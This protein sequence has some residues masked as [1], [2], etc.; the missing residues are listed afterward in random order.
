[1]N[2]LAFGS[3]LPP[4]IW[5]GQEWRTLVRNRLEGWQQSF[6]PLPQGERV[7]VRVIAFL[8]GLFLMI[9]P[10]LCKLARRGEGRLGGVEV[11]MPATRALASFVAL[12]LLTVTGLPTTT[13]CGGSGSANPSLSTGPQPGVIYYID[14]HLGSSH[15]ITDSLGNV[16]REESRFPYGLE[17]DTTSEATTADYVYTGKEYDAETGLIY[18]GGRYYAP[19]LGRWITPDPL[20]LNE[21]TKAVENPI[22]SNLYT[23][24][25][26]NP[27]NLID[28]NGFFEGKGKGRLDFRKAVPSNATERAY[29]QKLLE[30][31]PQAATALVP[32]VNDFRD[33]YELAS[34]RDL[35]TGNDI[36]LTGRMFSAFGLII[37]SGAAY[38]GAKQLAKFNIALGHTG[39][40][41]LRKFANKIGALT[42]T[43]WEPNGIV[44]FEDLT[45]FRKAFYKAAHKADSIHFNLDGVDDLKSAY[46]SGSRGFLK[47]NMT[48][49]EL[50][51]TVNDASL[52]GKTT[53]YRNSDVIATGKEITN[54]LK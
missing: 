41:A 43:D 5:P 50:Y 18:F 1:M 6:L 53:F 13:G 47:Y 37:G 40:G 31:G 33:A 17:R 28:P 25:R 30:A 32:I 22:S 35:I 12:I 20:Y 8:I 10:P 54:F 4:T 48:N 51:S 2:A 45:H 7:G 39:H 27:I 52:L 26:N 49:A 44:H 23:Y 24:V 16:V 9:I 3:Q 15:L 46:G 29:T 34:G 11:F 42:W 38:R 14:D 19:E 36:G 21:P